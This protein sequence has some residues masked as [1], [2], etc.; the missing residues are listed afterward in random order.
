MRETLPRAYPTQTT[1]FTGQYP[2]SATNWPDTINGYSSYSPTYRLGR[3]QY[4][5][6]WIN[7]TNN[8][9]EVHPRGEARESQ[10][11]V[12]TTPSGTKVAV[13]LTNQ[14]VKQYRAYTE[15]KALYY[16]DDAGQLYHKESKQPL[17]NLQQLSDLILQDPRNI[18]YMPDA[19]LLQEIP[20]QQNDGSTKQLQGI[21]AVGLIEF[22]IYQATS[23]SR[24]KN[25]PSAQD[26]VQQIDA[27]IQ[28]KD[29]SQPQIAKL[30][31]NLS[32][33]AHSYLS[34]I[35]KDTQELDDTNTMN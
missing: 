23:P 16:T 6:I 21:L 3:T 9:L 31:N 11:P 12:E 19:W 2:I 1:D 20:Y 4:G 15:Q 10:R 24:N 30:W 7:L 14:S 5:D 35:T 27:Y 32:Q 22:V 18:Q 26:I 8:Q 34:E 13:N 25:L 17:Y 28:T 29:L 33:S